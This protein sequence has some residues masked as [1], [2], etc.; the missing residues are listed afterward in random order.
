MVYELSANRYPIKA[1]IRF[2][3]RGQFEWREG[4]TVNISRSGVLFQSRVELPPGTMIAMKIILPL[5]ALDTAITV[6]CY[7][8]VVR[9]DARLTA[10]CG[11]PV[12]A[13]A[14]LRYRI[15]HE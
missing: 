3:V 6:R 5:D 11:C 14:I 4:T 10:K 9:T 8:R 12:L 7:G 2:R 15:S 1:P 13:A